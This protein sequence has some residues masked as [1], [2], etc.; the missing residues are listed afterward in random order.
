MPLS[1]AFDCPKRPINRREWP[2]AVGDLVAV[3]RCVTLA[4][5]HHENVDISD[6]RIGLSNSRS[7][8]GLRARTLSVMSNYFVCHFCVQLDDFPQN[9]DQV[10]VFRTVSPGVSP[11][12]KLV[13]TV[14]ATFGTHS[15]SLALS[16]SARRP[17]SLAARCI[18]AQRSGGGSQLEARTAARTS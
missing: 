10:R 4:R 3:W 16:S 14:D 13:R 12:P 11:P 1:A 5:F 2:A 17:I 15:L 6:E 8:S 18:C 7:Q 9:V